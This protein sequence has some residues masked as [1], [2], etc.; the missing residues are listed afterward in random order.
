MKPIKYI[1]F[2]SFVGVYETGL[3]IG[4]LP[5]LL[6]MPFAHIRQS[7]ETAEKTRSASVRI[8]LLRT[9]FRSIL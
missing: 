3:L 9:A 6:K 1:L 7:R 2:Y 4:A 8:T 5:R